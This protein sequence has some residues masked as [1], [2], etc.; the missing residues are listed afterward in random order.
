M[1]KM[2]Y[3]EFSCKPVHLLKLLESLTQN[4]HKDKEFCHY[5]KLIYR[6]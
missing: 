4:K 3:L 2:L 6:M 5:L 1:E